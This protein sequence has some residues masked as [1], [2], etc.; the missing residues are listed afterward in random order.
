M[1]VNRAEHLRFAAKVALPER[2]ELVRMRSSPSKESTSVQNMYRYCHPS[3]PPISGIVRLC[4]NRLFIGFLL[5]QH[6]CSRFP[7]TCV[8]S[9][10]VVAMTGSFRHK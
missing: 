7:S 5:G 8:C 3:P 10:I 9:G 4:Q 1:A 2:Q 6:L